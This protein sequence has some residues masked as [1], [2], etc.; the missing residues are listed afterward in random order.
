MIESQV[1]SYI[2]YSGDT[3]FVTANNLKVEYFREL[4]A[5]FTYIKNYIDKYAAAPSVSTFLDAMYKSKNSKQK[6]VLD[7]SA[8]KESPTFLLDG[9]IKNYRAYKVAESVQACRDLI[10]AGEYDKAYER[11]LNG[12]TDLG[13]DVSFTCTD[14]FSDQSRYDDFVKRTQNVSKYYVTTGFK[15]LD[16]V[17][18]GIDRE[19]ELGVI[20][21]RT[22]IGKSYICLKMAL[23]AAAQGLRVGFYSGEMTSGKVGNRMDSMISG[24]N[25]GSLMHG[26]INVQDQYR[27]YFE[28]LHQK[29]PNAS[30]NVFTPADVRGPIG[31]NVMKAYIE[32]YHFD[33]LFIDQLSLMDDD[34]HGRTREERQSNIIVDLKRLQTQKRI[35]IICIVQQN[36]TK[37]EDDSIDTTQIAGTDDIGKYATFVL[38]ISRDKKDKDLMTLELTKCRD[39]KVGAKLRYVTDFSVGTFNYI[40]EEGNGVPP[41]SPSPA[42]APAPTPAPEPEPE[43]DLYEDGDIF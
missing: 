18:F 29:Y 15:E 17:M 6:F 36:R 9:L 11:Y 3:T 20:M 12:V 26:N 43:D 34:R 32:K 8:A 5:E 4:S 39:G 10:V 27:Q 38:A 13:S 24:I 1:L 30:L 23:A 35:P 19:E 21:A 25:C 37:N 40:E 22:G 16:S 42:S 2:L 41:S 14:L 7:E 33:I 31:V 28:T